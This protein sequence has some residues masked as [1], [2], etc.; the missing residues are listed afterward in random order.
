MRNAPAGCWRPH[1]LHS[2]RLLIVA[3]VVAATAVFAAD[4]VASVWEG[5][6]SF[7]AG[8]RLFKKK[9]KKKKK[10]FHYTIPP[11]SNRRQLYKI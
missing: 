7:V 3:P 6:V 8:A 10:G 1:S 9:E 4:L 5:S 11:F 2:D